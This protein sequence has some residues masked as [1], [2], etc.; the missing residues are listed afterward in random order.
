MI[1]IKRLYIDIDWTKMQTL[2]KKITSSHID[3]M[4]TKWSPFRDEWKQGFDSDCCCGHCT[5]TEYCFEAFW[6]KRCHLENHLKPIIVEFEK[7]PCWDDAEVNIFNIISL[8]G[9]E[10]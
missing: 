7:K 10:N 5:D 6:D 8:K 2:H 9:G 1:A 4:K 3:C